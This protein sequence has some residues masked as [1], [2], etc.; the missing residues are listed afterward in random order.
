VSLVPIGALML[1]LALPWQAPGEWA[2]L[3][4]GLLV[5]GIYAVVGIS[6]VRRQD[7]P[8][9]QRPVRWFLL[10]A[11]LLCFVVGMIILTLDLDQHTQN[12]G[13]VFCLAGL[14]LMTAFMSLVRRDRAPTPSLRAPAQD[15]ARAASSRD[16]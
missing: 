14:A 16:E 12:S 4:A 13:V 5:C 8:S 11:S 6:A 3:C 2:S 1:A 10:I 15:G 7:R 9:W